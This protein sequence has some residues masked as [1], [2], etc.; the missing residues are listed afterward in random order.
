MAGRVFPLGARRCTSRTSTR[1]SK[2]GTRA[3]SYIRRV[4]AAFRPG[5]AVADGTL[6]LPEG[7]RVSRPAHRRRRGAR[8]GPRRPQRLV[9]AGDPARGA[10]RRQP[11]R[12]LSERDGADPA[13]RLQHARQP[14]LLEC[15]PRA[16]R[17]G[18]GSRRRASTSSR[19]PP[20]ATCSIAPVSRWTGATPPAAP[21]PFHPRA[22]EQGLNSVLRT[23]HRQ[24]FLV[25]P[26]RHRSFPLTERL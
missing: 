20:R 7:A 13:G 19:S 15:A 5:L 16:R 25:P 4:W 11:R 17:D 22:E 14:V 24:N 8:Q 23:T 18:E 3:S 21:P 2:P 10:G 1:T 6:I 12:S 9:A 26:R